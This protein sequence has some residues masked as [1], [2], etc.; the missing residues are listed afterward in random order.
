MRDDWRGSDVYLCGGHGDDDGV[1]LL[2]VDMEIVIP[3]SF[4][5]I[6]ML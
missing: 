4:K 3:L 5:S 1:A 2:V 6:R